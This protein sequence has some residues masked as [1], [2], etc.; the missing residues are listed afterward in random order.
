MI[1]NIYR[2]LGESAVKLC[3]HNLDEVIKKTNRKD[4][5][6]LWKLLEQCITT[7]DQR[8]PLV[9]F[10]M[11]INNKYCFSSPHS[12]VFSSEKFFQTFRTPQ[13]KKILKIA[14]RSMGTNELSTE[15]PWPVHP[16]GRE[17]VNSFL[18]MVI[19]QNFSHFNVY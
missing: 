19:V 2:L 16:F 15:P 13:N 10:F 11:S 1:L 6:A 9:L 8:F 12:D 5:V 14:L 7:R 18:G 17:M 4:L 3:R